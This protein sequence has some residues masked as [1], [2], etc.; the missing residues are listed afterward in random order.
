MG[1]VDNSESPKA[2]I[3]GSI[4][5]ATDLLQRLKTQYPIQVIVAGT[6]DQFL[7]DC[8]A[9]RYNNVV[10][11]GRSVDSVVYTGLFDVE[12]VAQLP[13]SVK[14]ICHNGAGYDQV[15]VHACKTRGISVSH[16]PNVVNAATAD[17]TILLMLAALRRM[18]IP[19]GAVLDGSWGNAK[20]GFKL[21]L[22]RDPAGLTLGII[23]LG[24]I[25]AAVARRATAFDM[26]IQYHNRRPADESILR[27]VGAEVTYIPT[28]A[29]LLASSDIVSVHVPL[30]DATH[31]LIGAIEF[32]QMKPGVVF[33]NT[34]RGPV[35]DEVALVAAVE[36]GQVWS[37]GLDVFEHEPQVHPGL[38]TSGHA[39]L[40]PHIGTATVDTRWQMEE[41]MLS[42]VAS[43]LNEGVLKTP[44][45]E[46][47]Q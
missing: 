20:S 15:D 44:V 39:V 43:A 27:G 2:L 29:E 21:P 47:R 36:S 10:A 31:H 30:S 18:R 6:R 1:S 17:T 5:H 25:G 37:A 45:S 35:V 13:L 8:K 24:G 42:N 9:G 38:V 23:G 32:A 33:I 12:L 28:L 19:Q 14:F 3:L 26:K 11:I 46:S 41:L 16:T 4:H 7:S 22:G 40:L 34:A